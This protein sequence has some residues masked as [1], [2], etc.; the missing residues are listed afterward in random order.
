LQ[1]PL[2]P[3]ARQKIIVEHF[4]DLCKR[5]HLTHEIEGTTPAQLVKVNLPIEQVAQRVPSEGVELGGREVTRPF[6]Y[7][8]A[9]AIQAKDT[10]LP[11]DTIPCDI[12]LP[13]L[14]Q[15]STRP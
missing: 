15:K 9:G 5:A 4:C 1:A 10:V 13:T 8:F 2:E 12:Y 14:V 3:T 7:S 6:D 11:C